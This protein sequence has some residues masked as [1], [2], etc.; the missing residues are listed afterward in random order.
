M[1]GQLD[2]PPVAEHLLLTCTPPLLR[3]TLN[4]PAL[5]NAFD[6]ALLADLALTFQWA[7]AQRGLRAVILTGAGKA[8]CAGADFSWMRRMK[9][10]SPEENIADAD[11]LARCL[12]LWD[13]LPQATICAVHGAVLGGGMGLAAAADIVIA[14]HGTTFGFPEVRIGLAP[15]TIAPFVTRRLG[16]ARARELFVTGRRFDAEQAERWG[17]VDHVALPDEVQAAVNS[18]LEMVLAGGPVA[19]AACKELIKRVWSGSDPGLMGF[20]AEM[21]ARLRTGAEGQE[22]LRAALAKQRPAW[23]EDSCSAES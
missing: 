14:A 11:R 23:M 18:S 20:T 6:D 3:L 15:A 22:G 13:S 5:R 2:L 21:I 17:F 10:Y 19:L 9:D 4:K 16:A 7:A 1:N 12:H 8:F